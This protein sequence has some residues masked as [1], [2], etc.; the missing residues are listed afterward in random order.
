MQRTHAIES[1]SSH[2]DFRPLSSIAGISVELRYASADNFVGRD[3]Y[4]PLDCAWLHRHAAEGLEK[5]VAWLALK[6]A[7]V[8]LLVLDALRPQRVQEQLWEALQGTE[9]L[10]YLANPVRGSIHSFGMAVDIT[11]VDRQGRELDMGTSFDDLSERSH[12]ALEE[13]MLVRGELN[14]AQIDNRRL[15]REAM[16]HGGFAGISSEWWH[17]DC[18]DRDAVR[19]GY[20]RVV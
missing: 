7:D 6:R 12:P 4:S 17:F 14:A 9:L 2:P 19:A 15:L 5:T 8:G 10:G 11:L 13:A 20:T 3:L 18:G 1:I 16:L